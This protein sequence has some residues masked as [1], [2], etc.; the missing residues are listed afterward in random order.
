MQKRDG[1]PDSVLS[2]GVEG[3]LCRDTTHEGQKSQEVRTSGL[4]L[5]G[6]R[7]QAVSRR[8]EARCRSRAQREDSRWETQYG[9]QQ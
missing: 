1:W 6:V 3:A 2:H 8:E 5:L 9:A 7:S 4:E